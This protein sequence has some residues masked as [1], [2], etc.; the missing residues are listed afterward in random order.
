DELSSA[1]SQARSEAMVERM[2]ERL[3]TAVTDEVL[4][5]DEA[6]AIRDWFG[7]KPEALSN[8]SHSERHGL[9]GAVQND[10]LAEFLAGLVTEEIISQPESDEIAGWFNV[11]PTEALEKFRP[12]FGQG[13]HGGQFGHGRGHGGFR[14]FGGGFPRFGEPA[15]LPENGVATGT[16][17]SYY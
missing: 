6:D 17:I 3:A 2:E 10:G 16:S 8:L 7:G 12:Q 11:R 5:Q 13:G 15:P 4:T 14:G 1:M 9:R